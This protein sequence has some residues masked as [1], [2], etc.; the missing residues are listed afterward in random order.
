[1][2]ASSRSP[3][4]MT[5]VP[6]MFSW[7]NALRMASTA[8]WSAAFSSPRPISRADHMAAASVR[9]TASRPMFL[10]MVCCLQCFHQP[11][12]RARRPAL[13]VHADV[14]GMPHAADF[15]TPLLV[16]LVLETNLHPRVRHREMDLEHVVVARRPQILQRR[17]VHR[18]HDAALFDLFVGDA[19]VANPLVARAFEEAE[20]RTVI[21]D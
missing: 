4:P 5:M 9:R 8:A 3:S 12:R 15:V 14:N 16:H 18:Q 13:A 1:M 10:S 19:E 11:V 6:R 7:L 20:V 21:D 17:L 2:G